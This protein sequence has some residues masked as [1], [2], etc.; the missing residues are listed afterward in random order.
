MS[1]C[2]PTSLA[3]ETPTD[4]LPSPLPTPNHELNGQKDGRRRKL[5]SSYLQGTQTLPP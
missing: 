1:L 2:A 4:D 5:L 3:N